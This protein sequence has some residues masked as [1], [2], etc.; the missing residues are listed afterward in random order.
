M[1]N[2]LISIDFFPNNLLLFFF[3]HYTHTRST[4][5]PDFWETQKYIEQSEAYSA[6]IIEVG[7]LLRLHL[8]FLF[9]FFFFACHW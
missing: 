6:A 5:Y 9:F 1:T 2:S 7:W 3:C 8:S 4:I